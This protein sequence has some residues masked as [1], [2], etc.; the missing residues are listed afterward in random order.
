LDKWEFQIGERLVAYDVRGNLAISDTTFR[1]DAAMEG[2]GLAYIVDAL[3][4]PHIGA[5]RLK[6]VLTAFAPTLPGF[7][8]N[9]PNGQHQSTKLKALIEYATR[10]PT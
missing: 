4:L 7:Y 3:A 10:Q 1:L 6:P 9:Y 8:L 2:I 5:K